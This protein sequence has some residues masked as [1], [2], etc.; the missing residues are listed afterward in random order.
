MNAG[1]TQN[2]TGIYWVESGVAGCNCTGDYQKMGKVG[3]FLVGY[4]PSWNDVRFDP[5]LTIDLKDIDQ[6]LICLDEIL[7]SMKLFSRGHLIF[8]AHKP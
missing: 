1:R 3:G 6:M 7:T 4:H 8:F 2:H 5:V